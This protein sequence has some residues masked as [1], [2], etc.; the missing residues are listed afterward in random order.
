VAEQIKDRTDA[1]RLLAE[2]L[3]A[4]AGRS[5]VIVLGLPRGGVQVAFEIAKAL[6][7]PLDVFLVRKLG[8]PGYEELAFGSITINGAQFIDPDVVEEFGLADSQIAKVIAIEKQEL[9][10]RA[11]LYR[12]SQHPLDVVGRTVIIVDDGVATGST[13]RAVIK[14]LREMKSA[15]IVV[16]VGAAPLRICLFLGS[17]ADEVVCLKMPGEFQA[18]G[19]FYGKFPQ[20]SDEEV[21]EFLQK[22]E[23][24]GA[25]R[26][27]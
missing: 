20:L 15:R 17:E 27:A 6:R 16:A 14:V 21:V 11:T 25:R 8:V 10:R 24:F 23:D 19:Q 3:A 13:I 1:G 18:V 12:R 5:D 4:Y 26:A 22:A 7:A 2:R 9:E